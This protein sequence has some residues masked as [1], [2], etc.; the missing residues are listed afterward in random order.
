MKCSRMC[1]SLAKSILTWT[2]HQSKLSLC[3]ISTRISQ[4]EGPA[5]ADMCTDGACSCP[6]SVHGLP[7]GGPHA[8]S[9]VSMLK[10]SFSITISARS[11]YGIIQRDVHGQSHGKGHIA[12]MG[13]QML[14]EFV[15]RISPRSYRQPRK[16]AS[17]ADM[18]GRHA[19]YEF[20]TRISPRISTRSNNGSVQHGRR[21]GRAQQAE[22]VWSSIADRIQYI[23]YSTDHTSDSPREGQSI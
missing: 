11:V 16:W 5:K 2:V 21:T 23:G 9:V 12:D 6:K 3:Q 22:I 19:E 8:E 10:M 20:S 17:N 15:Q 13:G 1:T 18:C 14:M 7:T 4:R